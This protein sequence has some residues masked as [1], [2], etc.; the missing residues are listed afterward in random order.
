MRELVR[1]V[2]KHLASA[3]ETVLFAMSVYVDS[4]EFGDWATTCD[5]AILQDTHDAVVA[6]AD[7]ASRQLD[8]A[9]RV[10]ADLRAINKRAFILSR[11]ECDDSLGECAE[12]EK[13]A[14]RL[15]A[16]IAEDVAYTRYDM[17]DVQVIFSVQYVEARAMEDSVAHIGTTDQSSVVES[18]QSDHRRSSSAN[19]QLDSAD[20]EPLKEVASANTAEETPESTALRRRRR[21]ASAE[22]DEVDS[23]EEQTQAQTTARPCSGKGKEPA[24]FLEQEASA[25][26]ER[27]EDKAA[28]EARSTD[29]GDEFSCNICF[30]T[31]TDPVLTIC[32][33]L[34]CWSCLVQW[35]ERSATCPVCKAGC[36]KDKV[37]PVYGRGREEKDPRLNPNLPNRP[38]G[39]RPPP[40]PRQH[41]QL[42]GFDPFGV[43]GSFHGMG[44]VGGGNSGAVFVGGLG[45]LPALM[46]FSTF[47][48]GHMGN[49]PMGSNGTSASQQP[50]GQ[51]AFASRVMMML[52][53]MVL[54]REL[55]VVRMSTAT[56]PMNDEEV[57]SE[58]NKMV[59]FIRQEALEKAREIK[60]KADEEFNIEKAKL[61][62]QE[63]INVEEQF[64]RKVKQAEVKQRIL[65]ST[66]I[67]KSRL[68]VLQARQEMLDS[69]FSDAQ[70]AMKG[71]PQ[72]EGKYLKLLVDLCV[73]AFVQLN[74]ET[75]NV[76]GRKV[77][78]ALIKRATEQAVALY[79]E[80]TGK[81][82]RATVVEASPLPDTVLGGVRVSALNDRI[83]VD[84]T[85]QARLDLS[86]DRMLP[87]LRNILFGQSP[88]RKFFN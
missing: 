71:I 16:T 24:D 79:K 15:A 30:D 7:A 59:A 62:R 69:V 57:F 49:L 18:S 75:V 44:R 52:A 80:K 41:N 54:M 8:T 53:A 47:S 28:A 39:Q 74:D 36:D 14:Y 19:S 51:Q 43:P 46:G 10:Y 26:G 60:V 86:S 48:T 38:A 66:L 31:A 73:Q 2:A 27:V 3:K 42:F 50:V 70:E 65:T 56:R 25:K 87:Q 68:Q 55:A 37:I 58:M 72:D 22:E 6:A 34:F 82:V 40:P 4:S 11:A 13:D 5:T 9:K 17:Q 78:M 45:L 63:S 81:A 77:D 84:N 64:Q 21:P 32:G 20:S 35:L 88:S 85:L 61:V 67:N 76:R 23:G 1:Q 83:S 29:G 33:H 12:L